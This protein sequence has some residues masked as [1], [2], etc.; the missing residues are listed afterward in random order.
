MITFAGSA[1]GPGISCLVLRLRRAD[2]GAD[3]EARSHRHHGQSWQPKGHAV[4]KATR[5]AGAKL[6]SLPPYSPDLNPIEQVFSKLTTL[7]RKTDP[8]TVEQT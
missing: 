2:L 5:S 8:R 7:R 1:N 6:F 3:A 4:R